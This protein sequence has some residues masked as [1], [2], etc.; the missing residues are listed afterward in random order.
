MNLFFTD[1]KRCGR[2]LTALAVIIVIDKPLFDY[3]C[4]N[5]WLIVKGRISKVLWLR[6]FQ[7][8]LLFLS[9]K[10]PEARKT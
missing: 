9:N 10:D 5:R 6:T 3:W 8:P 2:V 4:W 1:Y 7:F